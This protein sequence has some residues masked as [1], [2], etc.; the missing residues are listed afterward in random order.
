MNMGI[1]TLY[2]T[3]KSEVQIC[4]DLLSGAAGHEPGAVVFFASTCF[5]PETI[6][7]EMKKTFPNAAVFGCTTAGEIVSGKMLSDSVVAMLLDDDIVEDICVRIIPEIKT[8]DNTA[9]I[10]SQIEDHFGTPMSEIDISKYVGIVLIDGMSG[11]E[12]KLMDSI[13]NLTNFT[14][15]GGAAGDDLKFSETFVFADGTAASNAAVVAVMKLKKGFD[16][17]KTQS[18]STTGRKL[19]A[20][21]VD[22]ASRSVVAFNN[23]P[24]VKAYAASLG[25]SDEEAG[26]RF[27]SNPVGLM[28]GEEPYIRSPQRFDGDHMVFYCNIKKGMELD[29]MLS[30]DIV[31]DTRTA[32][33]NKL[34]ELGG[35]SGIINFHC[36]LRT[37]ELRQKEQCDEYGAIFKDIPTIGFSTYGEEYIGHVNQ[38]STML[39]FK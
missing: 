31:S 15:I 35:V 25:C 7:A 22:E 11:A 18:F 27:M 1:R 23:E 17:V 3:G 37:L 38:T 13:G 36:I 34:T 30:T 26:D 9:G 12:E 28:V 19:T 21:E 6:S 16:V 20:T 4:S 8:S 10:F 2:S 39:V 24:A 14:F 33:Q 32:V 5:D 29:L